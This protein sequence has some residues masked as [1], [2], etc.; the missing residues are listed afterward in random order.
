MKTQTIIIFL[1]LLFSFETISAQFVLKKELNMPRPGD[2][3]IK[4]QVE[5][6]DPGRS[7][8]NILWNFGQLR[9]IND[10]YQLSYAN[11]DLVNDSLYI[12]GLDTILP[13][14]LN[15]DELFVA[16]EHNTMY[17]YRCTGNRLWALGH[18][19]PTTI[20][21]YSEPMLAGFFPAA[22]QDS[23]VGN[24]KAVGKYSSSVPLKTQGNVKIVA[25]A[26]GMIVLP[27]ADTLRNVL[28]T[29]TI[30]TFSQP[31]LTEKED[32]LIQNT[33]VE[34]YKWYSKGYRYPIFE[35]IRNIMTVD[36][37]TDTFETA[38]FYPPQEQ[39]YLG[40]DDENSALR[41]EEKA[42]EKPTDSWD[43]LYYNIYPNPVSTTL[44]IE[45]YLP[46]TAQVKVQ[47]WTQTGSL[48]SDE[49]KGSLPQGLNLLQLNLSAL[50]T[51]NYVLTILLDNYPIS[52][53]I[54]KR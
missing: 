14:D 50:A 13:A 33:R 17:Y 16:T 31:V 49:N 41:E 25:E 21:R 46:R 8:A 43:D 26:Y 44:N 53:I 24:Y 19:N 18:E 45:L 32:S 4:Q 34:I 37:L 29:K 35:T 20:L 28:R 51:G 12:L 27:D 38:F 6:K 15:G 30:Q 2:E 54:M 5:Y 9:S 10:Q 22:Y 47:L 36:T 1:G 3:I 52:N 11:P 40:K 39:Y 42:K 23:I 7:G 48:F